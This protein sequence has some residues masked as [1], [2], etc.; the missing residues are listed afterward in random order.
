MEVV[1]F[2]S[3]KVLFVTRPYIYK[4]DLLNEI[5]A[6][7]MKPS[8]EIA[9]SDSKEYIKTSEIENLK[10]VYVFF[11]EN[12]II[13]FAE[14]NVNRLLVEKEKIIEYLYKGLKGIYRDMSV[15]RVFYYIDLFLYTKGL[16]G[17]EP[18]REKFTVPD[19]TI[20]KNT[21]KKILGFPIKYSVITTNLVFRV[22]IKTDIEEIVRTIKLDKN[23]PVVLSKKSG[24][25]V[26]KNFPSQKI[27]DWFKGKKLKGITFRIKGG[28][29]K[30]EYY[31]ASISDVTNRLVLRLNFKKTENISFEN[32]PGIVCKGLKDL[33]KRI[34]N[35]VS[36]QDMSI[37]RNI[38]YSVI[39]ISSKVYFEDVQLKGTLKEFS[40]IFGTFSDSSGFLKLK[41][42]PDKSVIIMFKNTSD[43]K[44]K[45]LRLIEISGLNIYSDINLLMHHISSL[46][47]KSKDKKVVK[48]TKKGFEE[49][50]VIQKQKEIKQKQDIKI[51]NERG[52]KIDTVS[53]Q[54]KRQ[55]VIYVENQHKN[56]KITYLLDT[57][58]S[59]T[60]VFCGQANDYIYP[61]YTS[62]GSICCFLKD[63]RLK[64]AFI[65]YNSKEEESKKLKVE[66]LDKKIINSFKT[67]LTKG[68]LGCIPEHLKPA[69]E[70]MYRVGL[71][72]R[73]DDS[74][75][76][77]YN[78]VIL[79][80][81]ESDFFKCRLLRPYDFVYKNT[82]FAID[83][84]DTTELLIKYN[85]L[86]DYSYVFDRDSSEFKKFMKVYEKSCNVI[87]DTKRDLPNS[88][89]DFIDK[90]I[91]SQITHK[92]M[93]YYLE[94][95]NLGIIPIIP[96]EP[97]KQFK[98][99]DYRDLTPLSANDQYK[100]LL[101]NNFSVIGVSKNSSPP[102]LV[103]ENGLG[104]PVK[105]GSSLKLKEIV[106]GDYI[107]DFNVKDSF[108]IEGP[109]E[110]E[111]LRIRYI[112][113]K[114][115]KGME[116][117]EYSIDEIE[118]ILKDENISKENL[119]RLKME[120][121]WNKN[122]FKGLVYKERKND[123]NYIIRNDEVV[124]IT[125]E[126]IERYF[127]L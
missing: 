22:D 11:I 112:F 8:E 70:G 1:D 115:I 46:I 49:T 109:F 18:I 74:L 76:N 117:R 58:V 118:K 10:R 73:I 33:T 5:S 64:P 24:I 71:G 30:N 86:S 34:E 116:H 44:G 51:L 21:I 19:L 120:T 95:K 59:G 89:K 53:C 55:P 114:K 38:S 57:K 97:I 63:Q 101:Q 90:G 42:I 9:L 121:I 14:K 124:L 26:L 7:T 99:I 47:D 54:K 35:I 23:I 98:K 41:Y 68:R 82:I 106:Y 91:V 27:E 45:S 56:D 85:S 100:L 29:T 62:Q 60:K 36:L 31:L 69:F 87:F 20:N 83:R 105:L 39:Q 65:K 96:R 123:K 77:K 28:D 75:R 52:L 79:N 93:V 16:T 48:L 25:R 104:V 92:G 80:D 2:I 17:I 50:V 81:N 88:F 126:E 119:Y 61:G 78:V 15:N 3:K 110:K 66:I 37:F 107:E 6:F 102:V 113:S 103:L 127:K 32:I 4:K 72:T 67:K 12:E 84:K 40:D 13:P 111:Y 125:P 122:I 43:E 94:V 108:N